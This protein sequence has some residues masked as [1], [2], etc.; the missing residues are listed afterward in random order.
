MPSNLTYLHRQLSIC[1]VRSVAESLFCRL[2]QAGV[3]PD[4]GTWLAAQRR[5]MA[6]AQQE[7]GRKERVAHWLLHTRGHRVLQRDQFL[8]F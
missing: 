2:Q 1:A 3:G 4:H 6:M 8:E 7:W 5:A